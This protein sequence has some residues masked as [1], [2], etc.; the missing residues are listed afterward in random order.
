MAQKN[1]ILFGDPG[2]NSVM[3]KMINRL[4]VKWSEEKLVVDGKDYDP[5]T[6]GVAMIYL[7]PMQPRKYVVINSGHTFH[8]PQFK[9][10]NA[11]LYPRLGDIAVLKFEK[12]MGDPATFHEEVQWA[13]IFNNSWRL[14]K[15]MGKE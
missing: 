8:E 2:S 12:Q 3:K 11:Q 9:A 10:S 7:N 14:P 15:P 5:D 4:P 6:H 13:A 1:M